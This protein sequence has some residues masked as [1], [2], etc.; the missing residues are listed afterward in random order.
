MY[1][2]RS[3]YIYVYSHSAH[4]C[5]EAGE[6]DLAVVGVLVDSPQN[7]ICH[8]VPSKVV[9]VVFIM[10]LLRN[11]VLDLNVEASVGRNCFEGLL[12]SWE[13]SQGQLL[14]RQSH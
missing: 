12:K 11:G 4:V 6:H 8:Q 10:P 3:V 7:D 9:K 13:G 5:V 2:L 14:L 1:M